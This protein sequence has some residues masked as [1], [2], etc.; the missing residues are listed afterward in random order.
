MCARRLEVPVDD[1]DRY[2]N[3]DDVHDESEE[4]IL[5]DEG[6]GHR[7]GWEDLGDEEEE[8]HEGKENGDAH[9]HLLSGVRGEIEH[10][11]AE[12]GYEDAWDY[13]VHRVE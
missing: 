10:A 5:G 6:D 3:C 2:D 7:G 12:E 8:D 11:D 9:G 4:K 13:Q 1:D